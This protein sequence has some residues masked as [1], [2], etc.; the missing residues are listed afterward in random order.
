MSL[1]K[2]LNQIVDF[3]LFWFV[4]IVCKIFDHFLLDWVYWIFC[5]PLL[6]FYESETFSKYQSSAVKLWN[7]LLNMFDSILE[8]I[9]NFYCKLFDL[10][11]LGIFLELLFFSI[12]VNFVFNLVY[13]VSVSF[14]P[15]ICH[16]FQ[17]NTFKFKFPRFLTVT[18]DTNI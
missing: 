2:I 11:R 18:R 6:D 7:V 8:F 14:D 13:F 1:S 10:F 17:F 5:A 9:V 15:N 12:L 4:E 16:V 3:F